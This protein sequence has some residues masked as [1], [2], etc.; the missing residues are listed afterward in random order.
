MDGLSIKNAFRKETLLPNEG[1]RAND[2]CAPSVVV[3]INYRKTAFPGRDTKELFF[4]GKVT[5]R[6]LWLIPF[7]LFL[8]SAPVFGGVNSWSKISPGP[9]VIRALAVDP[10]NR[11]TVYAGGE[12]GVYKSTDGG[13]TWRPNGLGL[14]C[15]SVLAL[16]FDPGSSNLL[17]A[18]TTN[19][20]FKSA[21]AGTS[22]TGSEFSQ[23]SLTEAVFDPRTPR[24]VYVGSSKGEIY[25]SADGGI[26]WNLLRLATEGGITALAIDPAAPQT[27]YA[28][29]GDNAARICKSTNGGSSWTDLLIP[30]TYRLPHSILVDSR[31]STVYL[32][33]LDE[34][35]K[36]TDGGASWSTVSKYSSFGGYA[37]FVLDPATSMLYMVKNELVFSSSG[38]SMYSSIMSSTNGGATWKGTVANGCSGQYLASA[39]HPQDPATIYLSG[40]RN[41]VWKSTDG[42]SNWVEQKSGL[43][44]S[45]TALAV[46]SQSSPV[47]FAGTSSL[48]DEHY[49]FLSMDGGGHWRSMGG[50]LDSK[51]DLLLP[52]P[53]SPG[54]IYGV[55]SSGRGI[56]KSTNGGAQWVPISETPSMVTSLLIH[57]QNNLILY[58]STSLNGVIKSTDSGVTWQENN[59]GIPTGYTYRNLDGLVMAASTPSLLYA[60]AWYRLYKSTNGGGSWVLVNS[61]FFDGNSVS[62]DGRV[63]TTLYAPAGNARGVLRSLDG[64]ASWSAISAGLKL[65]TSAGDKLDYTAFAGDPKNSATFYAGGDAGTGGPYKTTDGGSSWRTINSGFP[66]ADIRKILVDPSISNYLT[67]LT[68]THGVWKSTNGGD[69]WN[70]VNSGLRRTIADLVF[71]PISSAILYATADQG[72][73]ESNLYRSKDGG[74]IWELAGQGLWIPTIRS[75]IAHP[76]DPNLIYAAGES[77]VYK[78]TNAGNTW[79]PT[80]SGLTCGYA[81]CKEA[82]AQI[83]NMAL[84]PSSPSTLYAAG[85]LLVWKSTN[86]GNSWSLASTTSLPYEIRE[87]VVDPLAPSVVYAST[88]NGLYKTIDGGGHWERQG[89]L[90]N[91]WISAIAI[92][93]KR[94]AV[95]FAGTTTQGICKSTDGGSSW[96][97]TNNGLGSGELSVSSIAIHPVDSNQLIAG[98]PYCTNC[99]NDSGNGDFRSTDGGATWTRLNSWDSK[100]CILYNLADPEQVFA[101]SGRD[102]YSRVQTDKRFNLEVRSMPLKGVEIYIKTDGY[103]LCDISYSGKTDFTDSCYE[104]TAISLK[105]PTWDPSYSKFLNWVL[106]GTTIFD[107][108]LK[109]VMDSDHSAVA[110]FQS[111]VPTKTLAVRSLPDSGASIYVAPNDSAGQ[112]SGTAGFVRTYRQGD[113][114]TLAAAC[115]VGTN[116]FSRW[117][118]DGVEILAPLLTLTMDRDHTVVAI[119]ATGASH[120]LFLPMV[121]R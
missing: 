37:A 47:L 59:T 114:V 64:G 49:L 23:D 110:F 8:R 20:V 89:S 22:W 24:T 101:T 6:S 111:S 25:R 11:S 60:K 67:A 115:Q 31:L 103:K 34:L 73:W 9:G 71:S 30:D 44:V 26:G 40:N 83:S 72:Y 28:G 107:R 94:S 109:V 90:G 33:T 84:A 118:V 14:N 2:P 1:L 116:A 62:I 92:D 21:D 56:M 7:V 38:C 17:Y 51:L 106:D 108:E 95:L 112:G 5:L 41:T 105:T 99:T 80:V 119:Y 36:S 19:G 68:T 29:Y 120:C 78:T 4:G 76:Q 45:S 13:S 32:G 66:R 3:S 98:L 15:R 27:L 87:M 52:D 113:S 93:P 16:A 75:L 39:F 53:Q 18:A 55:T 77:G 82:I 58:A 42:G 104:G 70:P 61:N 102:L 96:V 43:E 117:I 50:G 48:E 35:M 12:G 74:K 86:S 81:Y 63:L 69:S 100:S 85:G 57:P 10:G 46:A 54:R 88:S 121:C 79:Q 91:Q 65:V 97:Q